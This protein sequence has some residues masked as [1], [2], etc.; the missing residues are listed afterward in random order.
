M[1]TILQILKE[2]YKEHNQLF[3]EAYGLGNLDDC[4]RFGAISYYIK[5]LIIRMQNEKRKKD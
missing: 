3:K 4:K 5:D 1:K 2:D